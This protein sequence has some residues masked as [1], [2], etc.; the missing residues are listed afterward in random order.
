[1]T[2]P[3]ATPGAKPIVAL[4]TEAADLMERLINNLV[5]VISFFPL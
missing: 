4:A 5:L 1:L 3:G 2:E